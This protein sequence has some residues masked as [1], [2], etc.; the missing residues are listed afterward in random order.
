MSRA[1]ASHRLM[2]LIGALGLIAALTTPA[3]AADPRPA[4]RGTDPRLRTVGPAWETDVDR[5]TTDTAAGDARLLVRFRPGTTR[6]ERRASTTLSGVSRI[7]DLPSSRLSV[8]RAT[9]A[10]GRHRGLARGS[11]RPS[12]ERRSPKPPPRRSDRRDLLARAVGHAQHGPAAVPGRARDR[13]PRRRRRR[14]ASR[15]M[16]SRPALRASSWRSS[17]TGSTSATRISPRRAW[18]NPGE[19]GA[20]QGDQRRR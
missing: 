20:R 7:A 17:T 18:T 3:F 16:P 12:R 1:P 6:A 10:R 8:V 14:P 15:L 11:R 9:D 4:S 13:G 19:S 5:T 2:A